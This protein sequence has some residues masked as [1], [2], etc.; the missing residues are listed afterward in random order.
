MHY[1]YFLWSEKL[2]RVYIGETGNLSNRLECHNLGLQRYTK[3]GVPWK[4]IGC[5][6]YGNRLEALKEERRLKKCKNKNYYK[7]YLI[8]N[9][10]RLSG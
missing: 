8:D 7:Q 1:L 9:C 2:R 4:L 5:R 3:R 10:F 6:K